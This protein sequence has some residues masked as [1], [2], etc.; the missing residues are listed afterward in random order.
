ML[1]RHIS[2]SSASQAEVKQYEEYLE[3]EG[4]VFFKAKST[5]YNQLTRLVHVSG[6]LARVIPGT[7]TI[8]SDFL[9]IHW[10]KD[11]L[12]AGLLNL[13]LEG[14]LQSSQSAQLEKVVYE[15]I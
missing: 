9:V 15:S 11:A 12:H 5:F 3:I 7:S 13:T 14:I 2:D 10:K 4:D 8:E 1:K 6:G